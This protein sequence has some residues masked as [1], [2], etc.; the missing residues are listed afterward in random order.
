LHN[1]GLVSEARG[2][3]AIVDRDGLERQ[4]CECRNLLKAEQQRLLGY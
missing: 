4:C 1:A 3:V 2:R